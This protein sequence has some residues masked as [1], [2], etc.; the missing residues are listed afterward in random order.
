MLIFVRSSYSNIKQILYKKIITEPQEKRLYVY[1][2]NR[3]YTLVYLSVYST[4]VYS[5]YTYLFLRILQFY[6]T[7]VHFSRLTVFRT[8]KWSSHFVNTVC[9]PRSYLHI[10]SSMCVYTPP[11]SHIYIRSR[12]MNYAQSLIYL[13]LYVTTIFCSTTLDPCTECLVS[14]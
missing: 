9:V 12:Y 11:W 13:T 1:I 3:R 5:I 7:D 6:T 10:Y 8:L 4:Y 2:H 14:V